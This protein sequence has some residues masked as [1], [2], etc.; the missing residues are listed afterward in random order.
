MQRESKEKIKPESR[1]TGRP[2]L[3][4]WLECDWNVNGSE[5]ILRM[6]TTTFCE[7]R[8]AEGG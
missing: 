8:A 5:S 3:V 1:Q 4:E 6:E 7:I 2:L